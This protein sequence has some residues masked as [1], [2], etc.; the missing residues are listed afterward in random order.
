[1]TDRALST[2]AWI[3]AACLAGCDTGAPDLEDT[4]S[5]TDGG[6]LGASGGT[7]GGTQSPIPGASGSGTSTGD[8]TAQDESSGSDNDP[9]DDPSTTGG[10]GPVSC[11]AGTLPP[12]RYSGV[13]L[14]HG[15]ESRSYDLY[16]PG[17]VDVTQPATLVLN[18]HGLLGNPAQQAMFSQYDAAAESAGVIVAYPSGISSSWNTGLCCGGAQSSGVDDVGF[19]RTLV[20]HIGLGSCIDRSKVFAIGMSNGGHMAHRL[21]CEAADVF[22]GVASV[23]G[24]LTMLQCNPSRPISVQQFHGTSDT[25]VSYDGVGPGF[26]GAR[27]MMLGWA[28]RNGCAPVPNV[29]HQQGDSTCETWT[30]CDDAVEVTLCTVEGGGHCWPGNPGCTF[31][32]STTDVSAND[33]FAQLFGTQSLPD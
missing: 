30:A 26:P 29:T 32:A 1:M 23:A 17:T 33:V 27:D 21:A 2:Y 24:V 19:A 9:T 18:F 6:T 12:G 10:P 13:S 22:A 31:G 5:G 15:G 14:E 28:Q 16:V 3:L 25:I 4:D 7:S 20:Q 11:N 8:S